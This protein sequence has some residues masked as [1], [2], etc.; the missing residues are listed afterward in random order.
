MY[1]VPQRGVPQLLSNSSGTDTLSDLGIE[2]KKKSR[3]ENM[4]VFL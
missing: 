2:R 1:L 4:I 3:W